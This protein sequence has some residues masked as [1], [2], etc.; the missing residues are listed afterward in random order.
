M[1]RIILFFSIISLSFQYSNLLANDTTQPN[2][3][4]PAGSVLFHGGKFE[5]INLPNERNGFPLVHEFLDGRTE[6]NAIVV[7]VPTSGPADP[8][9]KKESFHLNQK[10]GLTPW[11][12]TEVDDE[13][14]FR[15]RVQ[16][17]HTGSISRYYRIAVRTKDGTYKLIGG[18][19]S[20]SNG[21][22]FSDV[23][24]DRKAILRFNNDLPQLSTADEVNGFSTVY[25]FSSVL[26]YDPNEHLGQNVVP[27]SDNQKNGLFFKLHF[28]SNAETKEGYAPVITSIDRGDGEV[29]IHYDLGSK[30]TTPFSDA[31]YKVVIFNFG[32]DHQNSDI[33]HYNYKH[34]YE[35]DP[36]PAMTQFYIKFR[37][38]S[39]RV[40][41][42]QNNT[43]QH[44]AVAFINKH[45]FVTFASFSMAQTP[46][47]IATFLND[48]KCL[49]LS[50]GIP[51]QDKFIKTLRKFR[52]SILAKS[53]L[54]RKLIAFYYKLSHFVA[55]FI[56]EKEWL[57]KGLFY[58]FM[59][60]SFFY[61]HHL[62]LILLGVFLWILWITKKDAYIQSL[63]SF[64]AS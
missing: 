16:L 6:A 53:Y 31:L 18:S 1:I 17:K 4:L 37:K 24:F 9:N 13:K 62:L 34:I 38:A 21:G 12:S 44:F 25:C 19:T 39:V 20:N 3:S 30:I 51:P 55:P 29:T 10:Y 36:R 52:D 8:T 48:S 50:S 32:S 41:R 27:T 15:F 59:V 61:S 56:E 26:Q 43:E 49:L 22:A 58:P 7:Y 33:T 54:G 42:L 64:R 2:Q 45:Q 57:Q 28:N 5:Y 35:L 46:T 63:R 23:Y 40:D 47:T 60:L 14:L 11:H